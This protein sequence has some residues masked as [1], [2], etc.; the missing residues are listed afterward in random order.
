MPN[1]TVSG[2]GP[3]SKAHGQGDYGG[4]GSAMLQTVCVC[5]YVC[6]SERVNGFRV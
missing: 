2:S 3:A 5:M 1:R 4:A 6:E